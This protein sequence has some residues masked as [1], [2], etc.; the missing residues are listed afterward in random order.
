MFHVPVVYKLLAT[1]EEVQLMV[2]VVIATLAGSHSFLSPA[3]VGCAL[4]TLALATTV[5]HGRFQD[6]GSLLGLVDTV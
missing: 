4:S 3:D 2:G 6:C 5:R 1:A